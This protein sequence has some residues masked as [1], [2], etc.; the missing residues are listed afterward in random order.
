MKNSNRNLCF[1]LSAILVFMAVLLWY[2]SGIF[3]PGPVLIGVIAG[4][5]SVIELFILI[6]SIKGYKGCNARWKAIL[7]ILISL[8]SF[9]ITGYFFG[10]WLVLKIAGV[11]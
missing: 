7:I 8:V 2:T 1:S 4:I 11:W 3:Y 10:V 5:T 9:L 6:S